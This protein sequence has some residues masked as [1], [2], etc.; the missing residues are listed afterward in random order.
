MP[1]MTLAGHVRAAANHSRTEQRTPSP[2]HRFL[3]AISALRGGVG[4][5][6]EAQG[7]HELGC[8]RHQLRPADL[9]GD[10]DQHTQQVLWGGTFGQRVADLPDVGGWRGIQGD[11]RGKLDQRI[12][13]AVETASGPP[14]SPYL[15]ARGQEVR[16]ALGQGPE[17]TLGLL[18]DLYLSVGWRSHSPFLSRLPGPMPADPALVRSDRQPAAVSRADRSARSAPESPAE[19]QPAR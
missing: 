19:G 12:A 3:L 15:Q 4:G 9:R 1:G 7:E 17:Q 16:I 14:V 18:A 11:Q 5:Q 2:E 10:S 8:G 6:G 13:T